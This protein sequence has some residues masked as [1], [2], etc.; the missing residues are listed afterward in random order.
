MA[1]S[2]PFKLDDYKKR[3]DGALTALLAGGPVAV[4]TTEIVTESPSATD[5][6]A[7][8]PSATAVP[9]ATAQL[10]QQARDHYDRARAAQR[11]DDWATYGAEMHRLGDVL[12]QLETS[13]ASRP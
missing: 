2:P 5:T 8:A 13:R 7:R 3:M 4:D 6:T 1:A 10:V 12:Q 11:A 9:A